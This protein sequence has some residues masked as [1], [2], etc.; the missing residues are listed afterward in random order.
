MML[1][2]LLSTTI[3]SIGDVKAVTSAAWNY[4]LGALM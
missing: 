4:T 1:H 2:M 3:I